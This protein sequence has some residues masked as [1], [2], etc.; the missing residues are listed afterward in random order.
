MTSVVAWLDASADEQ[1]R[2]REIVQLFSQRETQDELGGRRIVVTLS[3]ALFPGTSVLQSRARYLLFV[4]W[5]AKT[6]ASWKDPV[7][8]FEWLERQMIKE[9]LAD[10]TVAD[11]DRLVGLIGREAGPKVKQL[12][13]SA[14]WTALGAWQILTVPGT[15]AD[16][17]RRTRV[18][19][20]AD[21]AA[22]DADEL[23]QRTGW[24]WHPGVGEPPSEFPAQ[25]VDG[26]FRLKPHEAEWLRE[27]WLATTD[28]SLLAHLARTREPLAGERA[29]WLEPACRSAG[30]EIIA[31]LDEA[32]RFSLAIDGARL[33]YQL[34]VAERYVGKGFDRFEVD[35]DA[36]RANID[37]WAQEVGEQAS[38]LDGWDAQAFW[39]FVRSRNARVDEITRRFFDV[40]FA[41]V[42]R[43]DVDGIADDDDL[44]ESVAARER[45]LK[46]GQARLENDKLL[47]GWQPSP[48]GRVTYRWS[49]VTRLVTDVIEGLDGDAG[50]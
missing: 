8:G 16:T 30:S 49:Q 2:V 11:S 19:S 6:A 28:G 37:D 33:L 20:V 12:P 43:A 48:P 27:R 22:A 24:V 39:A 38:L 9:F 31:V 15:I 21:D 18:G 35:L 45:F 5:F 7:G 40:W 42:I 46:R 47:A 34:M 10:T 26:G 3:D 36:A 14:Y 32:E 41:R 44:R 1:R 25:T 4:P 13:S 17:L 23:A 29:P 50:A